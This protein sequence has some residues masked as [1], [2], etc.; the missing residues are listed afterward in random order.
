MRAASGAGREHRGCAEAA[1]LAA[2]NA[3]EEAARVCA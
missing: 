1:G 3:H 2:V